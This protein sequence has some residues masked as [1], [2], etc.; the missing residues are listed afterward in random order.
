[1]ANPTY[2][3]ATVESTISNGSTHTGH[4]RRRFSFP[5]VP[6]RLD[7]NSS[8][9]LSVSR[10]NYGSSFQHWLLFAPPVKGQEKK[11]TRTKKKIEGGNATS[12][13]TSYNLACTSFA[14]MI[15]GKT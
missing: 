11:V 4:A 13:A 15:R 3:G 9:F 5:D 10:E 6:A 1:M 12:S 2:G 8:L 7:G 14:F